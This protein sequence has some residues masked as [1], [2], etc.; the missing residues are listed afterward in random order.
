[1]T[2]LK[3]GSE[4]LQRL[5]VEAVRDHN[6]LPL[7]GRCNLSCCFCSHRFNPPG[8]NAYSFGPLSLILLGELSAYLDSQQK[9]IIGESA[10]RLREGEPLTHPRFMDLLKALRALFP[11]TM[12]QVTTNG[13]LLTP[14]IIEEFSMLQP[15]ELIISLNSISSKGRR[16]L[17]GDPNPG[18]IRQL[19]ELL[20][21][22]K[23]NFQ[24]SVVAMPHLVGFEDLK[25]TQIFLD[26]SGAKSVR[27]LLPGFTRLTDP[28]LIP[29]EDQISRL[30]H[31][32]Y[33]LQHQL[34][35]PLLLEPPLINDLNPVLA[36]VFKDSPADKAG[37]R[38]G[39]LI[40]KI[41][42][43]Q[44]FSRVE[45]FRL[46][47]ESS[48]PALIIW[49]AGQYSDFKMTKAAQTSPGIAVSYDLDPDQVDRVKTSIN[50]AGKNLMLL[51]APALVRWQVSLRVG[52]IN[53]LDLLTVP[54]T[55]F[56]GTINCAGL[57]TVNDYRAALAGVANIQGYNC[58]LVPGISFDR[59][60]FDLTGQHYLALADGGLPLKLIQ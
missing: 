12:I 17:M 20:A 14:Q 25:Q 11:E 13:S 3:E 8:T 46:L 52:A 43:T 7:T 29:G 54:S 55:W 6:V 53:K 1:M 4:L 31:L 2:E 47:T 9:I 37:L 58:I 60:G 34:S 21:V 51:S 26:Q 32:V 35:A 15:L 48:D 28:E 59:G 41:N 40:F 36:G 5:L 39:D 22:R 30:Y 45:A 44:P 16:I 42:G 57:L 56:G 10:T 23:I 27:L 49:R 50:P 33:E 38:N 24:G 19:I 18:Q